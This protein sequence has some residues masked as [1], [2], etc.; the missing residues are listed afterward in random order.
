VGVVGLVQ[1]LDGGGALASA[2]DKISVRDCGELVVSFGSA[3]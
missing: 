2:F 3:T 1:L